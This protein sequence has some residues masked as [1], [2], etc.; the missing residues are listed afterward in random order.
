[1]AITLHLLHANPQPP[2][3]RAL[4][5]YFDEHAITNPSPQI[6]RQAVVAIR[7]SKLPDPR[8]IPNNGS[9]F[10][11]P[12]I[13]QEDT[14]QLLGSY[15]DMPHW[16]QDDGRVKLPAAWLVDQAG[17]K[18]VHDSETGIGTWPAQ[19]LVLVN[20]HAQTTQQLLTFRQK[21]IDAVQQRF[22]II[23]EQEPELLPK[24]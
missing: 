15:P 6:V 7:S 16:P 9:F 17:F 13:S 3:Y 11:N 14:V 18:D 1:M 2:F 8:T 19:A 22:G 23:L 5:G 24:E 21:I 20:E 4:Q 10:A 12:I